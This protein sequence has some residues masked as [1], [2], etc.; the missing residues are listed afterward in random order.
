[1]L[2]CMIS[3]VALTMAGLLGLSSR[4]AP[5]VGTPEKG[6]VETE[7]VPLP[8]TKDTTYSFLRIKLDSVQVGYDGISGNQL[9]PVSVA[10]P[11]LEVSPTR[12]TSPFE[13]SD[14]IIDPLIIEANIKRWLLEGLTIAE[15]ESVLRSWWLLCVCEQRRWR[16]S[17]SIDCD[18][19]YRVVAHPPRGRYNRFTHDSLGGMT[20]DRT[21]VRVEGMGAYPRISVLHGGSSYPITDYVPVVYYSEGYFKSFGNGDNQR[22]EWING[23]DYVGEGMIIIDHTINFTPTIYHPIDERATNLVTVTG[24]PGNLAT[25]VFRIQLSS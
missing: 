5:K 14:F 10:L 17:T 16:R 3:G 6:V 22:D 18:A 7:N 11:R 25:L 8:N 13:Y 12:F 19:L 24:A 15:C 4:E 9:R 20:K 1:M 2:P 21:R 23:Y